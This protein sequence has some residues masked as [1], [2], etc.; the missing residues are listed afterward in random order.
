MFTIII[1]GL[2]FVFIIGQAFF[3]YRIFTKEIKKRGYRNIG[4][5]TKKIS[6]IDKNSNVKFADLLN[7]NPQLPG[8]VAPVQEPKPNLDPKYHAMKQRQHFPPPPR[9]VTFSTKLAFMFGGILSAM[10]W[11]FLLFGMLFVS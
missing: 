4:E 11:V 2:F 6:S 1:F 7:T 9:K 10:G 8:G 5:F 3:V